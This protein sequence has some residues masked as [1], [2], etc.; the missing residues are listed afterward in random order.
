MC[1]SPCIY[2][3]ISVRIIYLSGIAV[4]CHKV[5]PFQILTPVQPPPTTEPV[6]LSYS[7]ILWKKKHKR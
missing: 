3:T 6:L 5:Y 4:S 7:L 1:P 2:S